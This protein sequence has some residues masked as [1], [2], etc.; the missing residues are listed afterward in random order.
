MG[1]VFSFLRYC[2]ICKVDIRIHRVGISLLVQLLR[3]RTSTAGHMGFILGLETKIW[4]AAWCDQ[5]IKI[6][7]NHKKEC[8]GLI[9]ED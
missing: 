2:V 5:K 1:K 3:L 4:H 6:I 8:T 7:K 9:C